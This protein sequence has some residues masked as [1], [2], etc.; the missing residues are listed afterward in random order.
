MP[1]FAQ[2]SSSR[3]AT[4][5]R[6]IQTIFMEVV[7]FYDCSIIEGHRTAERQNKHWQKGR[8]NDI[9]TDKG[10]VVTYKDGYNKKSKHQGYPS[11]AV[12]VT[13][14]PSMWKDKQE[15]QKLAAIVKWVQDMLYD[16]GRISSKLEWGG[17]WKSFL[18][19]PHWQLKK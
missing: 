17:D 15:F 6:D 9:I 11:T 3:L 4:C 8:D 7:K 2:T 10:K 19:M 5:D 13:P 18:D 1:I 16:Q 14:Y 12:D